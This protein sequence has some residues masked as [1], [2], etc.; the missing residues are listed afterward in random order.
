MIEFASIVTSHI[1]RTH[2]HIRL[3]TV[4]QLVQCLTAKKF[5]CKQKGVTLDGFCSSN[6]THKLRKREP[7]AH[8]NYWLSKNYSC[9]LAQPI[10]FTA[11]YLS[12]IFFSHIKHV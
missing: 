2:T 12:C 4:L 11:I 1:T 6:W 3:L 5:A 9:L 7:A 10:D 8:E